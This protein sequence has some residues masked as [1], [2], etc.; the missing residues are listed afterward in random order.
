[1]NSD[2]ADIVFQ[3]WIVE[4]DRDLFNG[5]HNFLR[6]LSSLATFGGA[7]DFRNQKLLLDS[8]MGEVENALSVTRIPSQFEELIRNRRQSAVAR[9]A[10]MATPAQMADLAPSTLN[11][12]VNICK[13]AA[14]SN[15]YGIESDVEGLMRVLGLSDLDLDFYALLKRLTVPDHVVPSKR[16]AKYCDL[17]HELYVRGKYPKLIINFFPLLK[18]IENIPVHVNEAANQGERIYIYINCFC[19]FALILLYKY[20]ANQYINH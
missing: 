1:M 20:L 17:L 6:V 18:D 16:K 7:P 4:R 9:A 12:L 2:A 15:A 10:K 5:C 11:L 8:L 14:Q 3:R 13:G 19:L